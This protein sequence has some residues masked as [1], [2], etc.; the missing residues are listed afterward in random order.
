MSIEDR[1]PRGSGRQRPLDRVRNALAAGKVRGA[2][3]E[4]AERF[5]LNGPSVELRTAE[6][7]RRD[8]R[9]AAFWDGQAAK[10]ADIERRRAEALARRPQR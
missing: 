1:L 10:V 2:T 5:G 3:R 4:L 9:R 8:E 6:R 7:Q